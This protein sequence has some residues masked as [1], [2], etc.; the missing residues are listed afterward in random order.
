MTSART[1]PAAR[2]IVARLARH[3]PRR[4]PVVD[5]DPGTRAAV[6]MILHAS[7]E[8]A[9]PEVLFIERARHPADPWSG[10]M[11]FPGGRMD[12]GDADLVATAARETLEEVG[13][14]LGEPIGRLD[15]LSNARM[16]ERVPNV[17][18]VTVTPFVYYC[19]QRPRIS[20]NHEVASTVWIPFEHILHPRAVSAYRIEA[21]RFAGTFPAFVYERYQVWGLTYRIIE[22][23]AS[24]FDLVLPASALH[25]QT[26]DQAT[27]AGTS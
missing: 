9:S 24:L 22:S 23:F 10:Q 20:R 27:R 26:L 16:R 21:P 4:E 13:I 12:P 14:A 8:L 25:S 17:G 19:E 6:A 11:A 1:A 2:E 7:H 3:A 18:R 5:G 15:E